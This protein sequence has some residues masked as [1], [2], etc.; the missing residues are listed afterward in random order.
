M[1][2]GSGRSPGE[3]NATPPVL[4]PGESHG[5]RSLVDYSPWDHKESDMTERLHFQTKCSCLE[6]M[7]R[8][9]FHSVGTCSSRWRLAR[10]GPVVEHSLSREMRA[11]SCRQ[12]AQDSGWP[13]ASVHARAGFLSISRGGSDRA[14]DRSGVRIRAVPARVFWMESP[15][16]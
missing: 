15:G 8:L 5:Q 6:L 9:L 11:S 10:G 2:P 4:L 16:D 13:T 3:G 7:I 12:L 14:W 1:I